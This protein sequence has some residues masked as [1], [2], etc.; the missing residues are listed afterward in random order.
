[1]GCLLCR[2]RL[3]RHQPGVVDAHPGQR[4]RLTCRAEG[5]PPPSV[6]WQRDGQPLSS[7]RFVQLLSPPSWPASSPTPTGGGSCRCP[8]VLSRTPGPL[9]G[10]SCGVGLLGQTAFGSL[11]LS[12]MWLADRSKGLLTEVTAERGNEGRH[13]SGCNHKGSRLLS[14]FRGEAFLLLMTCRGAPIGGCYFT[15]I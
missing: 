14:P 9:E 11:G 12:G 6:E 1:M 4:I 10:W 5:F 8:L 2:L 13:T 15:P 3:D 7:P